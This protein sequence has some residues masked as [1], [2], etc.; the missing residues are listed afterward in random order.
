MSNEHSAPEGPTMASWEFVYRLRKQT[1]CN[2][3]Q[4]GGEPWTIRANQ[5][6][7]AGNY[8]GSH[9]LLLCTAQIGSA[10][11]SN[12]PLLPLCTQIHGEGRNR[13][14]QQSKR[15][16]GRERMEIASVVS[17]SYWLCSDLGKETCN[18][19]SIERM[20]C[21]ATALGFWD[22]SVFTRPKMHETKYRIFWVV[23]LEQENNI[24]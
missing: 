23:I 24:H 4:E 15:W 12:F 19:W 21:L 11:Y 10:G 8:P 3:K 2:R 5:A 6:E 16:A 13:Q 18:P 22:F 9:H 1:R 20:Y 17:D 7:L 14:L